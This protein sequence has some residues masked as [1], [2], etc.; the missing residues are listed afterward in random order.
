M[1][2]KKIHD[3]SDVPGD[4]DDND[5]DNNDVNLKTYAT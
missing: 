2:F 4:Y 1:F 3:D 5:N